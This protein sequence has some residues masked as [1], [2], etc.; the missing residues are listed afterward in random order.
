MDIAKKIAK[1]DK[2]NEKIFLKA[3]AIDNN[4]ILQ[5]DEVLKYKSD[6]TEYYQKQVNYSEKGASDLDEEITNFLNTKIEGRP[7]FNYFATY[8]DKPELEDFNL[9]DKVDL[10]TDWQAILQ[11]SSKIE[12]EEARNQYIMKAADIINE[13]L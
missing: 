8:Q 12:D 4:N 2:E 10:Y 13:K 1:R 9:Q 5:D 3:K 11:K 7:L 6:L